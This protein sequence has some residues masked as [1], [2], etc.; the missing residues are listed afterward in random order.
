MRRPSED[1]IDFPVIGSLQ[2]LQFPFARV[3]DR[4]GVVVVGVVGG[5]GAVNERCGGG[6]RGID[7]FGCVGVG[8]GGTSFLSAINETPPR[9]IEGSVGE[10]GLKKA[11]GMGGTSMVLRI[12]PG[13]SKTVC[14]VR[15]G[16]SSTTGFRLSG[17]VGLCRLKLASEGRLDIELPLRASEADES[18]PELSELF[19]WSSRP[20]ARAKLVT[21]NALVVLALELFLGASL[22]GSVVAVVG[23]RFAGLKAV[24]SVL[25]WNWGEGGS[26]GRSCSP[27]VGFWFVGIPKS[28]SL[29]SSLLI[30]DEATETLES[31]GR[32]VLLVVRRGASG[33]G[34]MSSINDRNPRERL[35]VD[36][37]VVESP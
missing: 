36:D 10:S 4:A 12:R 30:R 18:D 5:S 33:T 14:R 11:A 31:R 17:S 29:A 19:I 22:P 8:V 23:W 20:R 21:E 26:S 25:S 13:T 3:T 2:P 27:V 24:Y 7:C 9:L 1:D 32:E 15:T 34:G 28:N 35:L 37:L 6:F 16:C